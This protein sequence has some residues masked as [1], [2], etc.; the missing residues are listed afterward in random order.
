VGEEAKE[1][2]SLSPLGHESHPPSAPTRRSRNHG[3]SEPNTSSVS[4]GSDQ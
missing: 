4:R 2:V 1:A 3:Q